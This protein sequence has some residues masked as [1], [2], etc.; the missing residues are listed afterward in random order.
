M[1]KIAA[2]CSHGTENV[3]LFSIHLWNAEHS[4]LSVLQS[5]VCTTW[6]SGPLY[7]DGFGSLSKFLVTGRLP[8]VTLCTYEG[9]SVLSRTPALLVLTLAN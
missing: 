6:Q 8:L 1:F 7:N 2:A 3:L 5:D 9:L 4:P